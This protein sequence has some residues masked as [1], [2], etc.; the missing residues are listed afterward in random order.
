MTHAIS[1]VILAEDCGHISL[2]S[3]KHMLNSNQDFQWLCPPCSGKVQAS[4]E[5]QQQQAINGPKGLESRFRQLKGKKNLLKVGHINID[6]LLSKIPEI[7]GIIE[8]SDLDILSITET[9]LSA[10]ISDDQLNIDSYEFA[11]RDRKEDDFTKTHEG[12][13]GGC[14]IYYKNDLQVAEMNDKLESNI[15]A[16]WVELILHSQRVLIGTIYGHPKDMAFYDKFNTVLEGIW[17]K[18]KNIILSGDFNSDMKARSQEERVP[19]TEKS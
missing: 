13:W 17:Q 10:A 15:E 6:G 5:Q 9:H 11:R 2:E 4:N 7:K 18:R 14:L 3:Y 19:N 12:I 1:G 8:E 16:V